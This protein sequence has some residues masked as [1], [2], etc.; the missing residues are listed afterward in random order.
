[1]RLQ[2]V[3]GNKKVL[4]RSHSRS[5]QL[6]CTV[7]GN[8]ARLDAHTEFEIS[9]RSLKGVKQCTVPSSMVSKSFRPIFFLNSK[10]PSTSDYLW[11]CKFP[12]SMRNLAAYLI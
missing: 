12:P 2:F 4:A 10:Q 3:Q 5:L 6:L 9:Q 1:V 8:Q 11:F 7:G